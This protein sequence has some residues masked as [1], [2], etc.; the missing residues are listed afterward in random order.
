MEASLKQD[1]ATHVSRKERSMRGKSNHLG[2]S[3]LGRGNSCKAVRQEH[4]REVIKTGKEGATRVRKAR[5][6]WGGSDPG[7]EGAT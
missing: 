1:Q 3:T 5:P 7:E 2:E 4:S 6:A